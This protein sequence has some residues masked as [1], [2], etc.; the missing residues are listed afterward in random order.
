MI[1]LS[2]EH[3]LGQTQ[4]LSGKSKNGN[5][6]FRRPVKGRELPNPP[7]KYFKTGRRIKYAFHHSEL[8]RN[9]N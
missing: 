1:A 8:F 6:N 4:V 2:R 5:C 9:L 3:V 7:D